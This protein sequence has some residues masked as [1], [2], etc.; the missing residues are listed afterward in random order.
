M[1]HV[2]HIIVGQGLA[3]SILSVL[4]QRAGRSVLLIDQ[5][6]DRSSS[7]VAAGTINPITGRQYVKSWRIDDLLPVAVDFYRS[8]GEEL[9]I[10]AIEKKNILR[11]LF[12]PEDEN[13]WLSRSADPLAAQYIVDPADAS[14][15]DGLIKAAPA[16]GE[17][18]HCYQVKLPA[19]LHAIRE[20]LSREGRLLTEVFDHA[21]LDWGETGIQYGAISA[22]SIVFCEGHGVVANPLF[23][24]I[25]WE[26]VKGEVL[27]I[28]LAGRPFSK[29]VRHRIF[30]THLQDDLY[31]VGAGYNKKFEDHLPTPVERARLLAELDAILDMPF[32]V[33]DHWA[34]IRPAV[35]G[36]RPVVGPHPHYP[37]I[38]IFNGL[39][40]KGSSLGPYFGQELVNHMIHGHDLDPILRRWLV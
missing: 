32:E 31:W 12:T 24:H 27:I 26:P 34:G 38:Y 21:K 14:S 35:M 17:L 39:G 15:C 29:V 20:R 25:P 8:L 2:D 3:G 4:L 16:Y 1:K 23:N 9:G 40:T 37:G 33:V 7:V 22:E 13:T 6:H 10:T 36:R 19:L 30:I 5:G 11:V 18:Q 28:R